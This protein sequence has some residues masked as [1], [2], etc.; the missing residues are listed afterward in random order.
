[1]TFTPRVS[2]IVPVYNPGN[3][4]RQALDSAK[5]Q[6]YESIEIICVNDGSTDKS[7][8][9]LREYET[10]DPRFRV[11]D[12]QN[13]GYGASCNRGLNE[14]KGEWIAILEPDDYIDADMVE[15]MLAFGDS[16]NERIDIIKTPYWRIRMP[17]VAG[18]KRLNCSYKNLVKH[19]HQPF[20]IAEATVYMSHHPSIWS[21]LY[22]RDYLNEKGIRFPELP[23]AG[24]ADNPFMI[25]ALLQ[26]DKIVYLDEP[27][28]NYRE[29]SK[30]KAYAFT[31]KT[32]LI[33]FERW[34]DMMDI[35]ERLN[36]TDKR[37]LQA[38]NQRG[39]LYMAGVLEVVGIDRADVREA[40]KHMFM[41]MNK[42]LVLSDPKVSPGYKKLFCS[43]LGIKCPHLNYPDYWFRLASKNFYNMRNIGLKQAL[44]NIG[45]FLSTHSKRVG[46]G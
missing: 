38:H 11:I 8:E 36:V 33:P 18:Q 14:A 23:G 10:A 22:R 41:R 44:H 13:E 30:E 29:D 25:E 32:P 7:L 31:R 27:F 9:V 15:K 12:K 21:A 20:S 45:I 35:I 5:N 4:L 42:E 43:V 1:M 24:W 37:I 2:F 16:F 17:E 39:F 6:T 46:K 3:Y 26:T 28:Y 19:T 34:N 40:T